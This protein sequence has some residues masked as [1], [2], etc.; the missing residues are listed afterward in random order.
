MTNPIGAPPPP[1]PTVDDAAAQL[2]RLLLALPALA[3]GEPHPITDVAA[4]AGSSEDAVARDLRTLVTRYDN[5]P[6]GFIEGVQLAFGSDT[7]RLRSKLF[8]RPMGLTPAE[9]AALE[10]G[11]AAL[12]RELPPHESAVAKKARE[13]IAKAAPGVAQSKPRRA[14][15]AATPTTADAD[16]LHLSRLRDA[17]NAGS[18]AKIV[19]RSGNSPVGAERSVHPYG[20]VH[21]K[22]WYLVAFCEK[23]SSIRI[24]RLDRMLD[25]TVLN[26][27]ADIPDGVA[28]EETLHHGRALVTQAEEHLRVRYSA[29][30]ARWITEHETSQ[31]QDDGSVIVDHPLLDDE[32]AVRHVLQYGP[33]AVV[34]APARI[35]T[36]VA[37]RL[38]AIIAS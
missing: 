36:L 14:V 13:R 16:G 3:D 8:R 4:I 24:F 23:A 27:A 20:L 1:P 34:L 22:H 12:Q 18:K 28:L 25:V 17:I 37:E 15:H 29:A 7:V 30:I 26:D 11:L 6:G 32:W 9:L 33:D 10:L 38:A 21:D 19:Y 35:R 2:R 31:A 5:D